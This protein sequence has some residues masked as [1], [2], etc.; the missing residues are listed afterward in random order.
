MGVHKEPCKLTDENYIF[1]LKEY[2]DG[3]SDVEIKA[4]IWEQRGS[5]SNDLWDRWLKEEDTFSET[6]KKGRALSAR[7]WEKRGR[8]R[9]DDS[10]FNYTGW[11]MNMKNRFGWKDKREDSGETKTT[12]TIISADPLT[13]K[14][15][16]EEH[17]K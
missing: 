3:A 12:T 5:F 7:W 2:S 11:Y 13:S 9:L 17:G 6:I 10:G 1:I 14:Q 16:E 8:T 4:Y 15:W